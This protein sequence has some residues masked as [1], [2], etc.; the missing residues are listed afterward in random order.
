MAQPREPR[1]QSRVQMS[2]AF[3]PAGGFGRS[4]EADAPQAAGV[5]ASNAHVRK[6]RYP[7]VVDIAGEF[8]EGQRQ[9]QRRVLPT[10]G[11][12]NVPATIRTSSTRGQ[13]SDVLIDYQT[14]ASAS[15]IPQVPPP[16]V[17]AAHQHASIA[18]LRAT[19]RTAAVEP[20]PQLI[21]RQPAFQL[22]PPPLPFRPP[23]PVPRLLPPP[24]RSR[25]QMVQWLGLRVTTLPTE[26]E[27][28]E[29]AGTSGG[30]VNDRRHFM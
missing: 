18:S 10:P 27:D 9:Q 21:P 12:V 11:S 22:L 28:I 20:S 4:R 29:Q 15:G 23:L 14:T 26:D 19:I 13:A 1:Q 25:R 3:E 6:P 2:A 24:P 8:D 30:R 17:R 16:F 5:W 7:W